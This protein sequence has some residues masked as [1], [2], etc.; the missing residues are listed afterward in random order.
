MP[1][2]KWRIDAALDHLR[3][4]QETQHTARHQ[5]AVPR[6][7]SGQQIDDRIPKRMP[8]AGV[9]HFAREQVEKIVAAKV[10]EHAAECDEGCSLR[11]HRHRVPHL[12]TGNVNFRQV[13]QPNDTRGLD[14]KC[15]DVRHLPLRKTDT[16]H[17]RFEP[18]TAD[19]FRKRVGGGVEWR[20]AGE[21][22]HRI[23]IEPPKKRLDGQTVARP[24]RTQPAAARTIDALRRQMSAVSAAGLAR[25]RVLRRRG[26]AHRRSALR[27]E[28]RGR[29]EL[30]TTVRACCESRQH[31]IKSGTAVLF[32]SP[33]TL[34]A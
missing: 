28:A 10:G 6:L 32:S 12:L 19:R 8:R 16:V 26:C 18:R 11:P 31:Q 29:V 3:W 21:R 24:K 34:Q 20:D 17:R 22:I 4:R 9:T 1:R 13:R 14:R 7:P 23:R 30:R 33:Q 2:H 25:E 5:R 15:E 27:A